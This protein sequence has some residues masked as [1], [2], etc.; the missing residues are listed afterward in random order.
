MSFISMKFLLF[1]FFAAAGY[2]L[3]PKK[4]QWGWLLLFSYLYYLSSGWK[5]TLFLIYVTMVTYGAGLALHAVEERDSLD[6]RTKKNRKKQVLILALVLDFG[7]LAIL[8]YTNFF[9]ENL[10]Y[11]FHLKLRFRSLILPI[12]LSFYTFQSAGYLMDVY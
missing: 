1:I 5:M 6:K 10:D 7:L 8:K 2:Y 12:G 9:I 3:I 4:W 11:L